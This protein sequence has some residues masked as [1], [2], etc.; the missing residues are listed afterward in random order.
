MQPWATAEVDNN[1]AK[2]DEQPARPETFNDRV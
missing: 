1:T 2:A